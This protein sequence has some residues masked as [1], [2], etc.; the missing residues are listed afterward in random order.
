MPRNRAAPRPP[1]GVPSTQNAPRP[2]PCPFLSSG[3]SQAGQTAKV[4]LP[5]AS[6]GLSEGRL[7]VHHGG[8]VD[9]LQ[10]IDLD[11]E[12]FSRDDASAVQADRVR[13]VG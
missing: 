12:P 10:G 4:P 6:G 7:D 11:P 8:V 9:R 3:V 2:R 1:V 5:V 13:P